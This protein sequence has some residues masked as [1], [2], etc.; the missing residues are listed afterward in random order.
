MKIILT[1][2]ALI[3]FSGFVSAKTFDPT[4]PYARCN[5]AIGNWVNAAKT[6]CPVSGRSD[7]GKIAQKFISLPPKPI[8]T[9]K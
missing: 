4:D 9:V 1:L 3:A 2:A 5:P 6:T 7:E 8:E